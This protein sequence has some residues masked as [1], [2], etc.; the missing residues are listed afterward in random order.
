MSLQDDTR[1]PDCGE[2]LAANHGLWEGRWYCPRDF[3]LLS[4]PGARVWLAALPGLLEKRNELM[5]MTGYNSPNFYAKYSAFQAEVENALHS[6][7][8]AGKEAE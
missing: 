7:A 2:L 5:G 1:C 3:A 8:V 4:H 6:A